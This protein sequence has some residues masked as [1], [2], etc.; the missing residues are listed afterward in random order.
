MDNK[1]KS[2]NNLLFTEKYRPKTKSDLIISERMRK[3]FDSGIKQNF[4]FY[5]TSGIGKTSMFR[6][7]L[8][9]LPEDQVLILSGKC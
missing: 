8:S 7:M 3:I 2:V 6:V 4:L 9:E 1:L 5:G